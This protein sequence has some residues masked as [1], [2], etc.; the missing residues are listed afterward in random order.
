MNGMCPESLLLTVISLKK[1]YM[2]YQ[3]IHMLY[4]R[5]IHCHMMC[6]FVCIHHV[7]VYVNYMCLFCKLY[8]IATDL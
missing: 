3:F 6:L 7:Y 2:K 1:V 5:F 8:L 4:E